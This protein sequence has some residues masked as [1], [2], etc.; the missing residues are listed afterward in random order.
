MKNYDDRD[1]VNI[2]TGVDIAIKDLAYLIKN[3]VGYN[4]AIK[5]I[6]LNLT[7]IRES[8]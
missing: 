4:G 5:L 7:G 8:F 1:I 2:G 6:L 3:I